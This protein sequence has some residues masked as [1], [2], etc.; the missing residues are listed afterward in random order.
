MA[1]KALIEAVE[2]KVKEIY[3]R[4]NVVFGREFPLPVVRFDLHNDQTGEARSRG[5][6]IRINPRLL[7]SH[8]EFIIENTCP[9]ECAHLIAWQYFP[10]FEESHGPQWTY[11][12]KKLGAPANVCHNL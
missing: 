8:P 7:E 12:V 6:V 3:S 1:S 9:H 11:T 4:A 5:N 10:D 2:N